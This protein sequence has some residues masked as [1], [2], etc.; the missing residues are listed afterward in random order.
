MKSMRI[1]K[2]ALMV[3]LLFSANLFA[4]SNPAEKKC[5]DQIQS[6]LKSENQGVVE[7][8]IFI[9]LSLKNYFPESNYG[10]VIN[11]LNDLVA[12]GITPVIK[13]KAQLASLYYS[14][15]NLFSDIKVDT[16]ENAETYFKMISERLVNN[17]LASN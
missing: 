13:Y 17:S 1:T 6:A 12:D 16:K 9:S 15:P 7:S 8:A 2:A 5:V 11:K 3:V 4:S 10:K 14:Y